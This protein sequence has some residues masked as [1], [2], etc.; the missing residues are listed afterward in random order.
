LSLDPLANARDLL[1][2]LS[3]SRA[4]GAVVDVICHSRGGLVTRNL[5]ERLLPASSW[6][7]SVNRIVFVGVPNGGT[8]LAERDRWS[9]LVD[10]Y[11]S[12]L[13][14]SSPVDDVV[15]TRAIASSAIKGVGALVKYLASYAADDDGVPGL[16]AM[17]SD[18]DF[19]VDLNRHQP[20]QPEPGQPWLVISS[21]FRASAEQAKFKAIEGIADNLLDGT[22][23][24][25][26][27]TKSMA[28]VDAP[29]AYA[30]RI[31][32]FGANSSVYHTNYFWPAG[33]AEAM[34][35]AFRN[36]RHRAAQ[37]PHRQGSGIRRPHDRPQIG[38]RWGQPWL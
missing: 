13:L 29:G 6:R 34:G 5:V 36:R 9:K 22:N 25:V 21:D 30:T 3:V 14:A 38:R 28:A 8:N 4:D 19:I 31:L 15:L 12:L 35:V 18:G 32:D 33:V 7:G 16:A 17:E 11:T 10:V 26:V 37:H 24:L 1:A 2:R 27:E 20:G 23:D